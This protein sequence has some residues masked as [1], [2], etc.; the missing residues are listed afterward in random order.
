[1]AADQGS[2]HEI[3][4]QGC[5]ELLTA[6]TVGRVAF[7]DETGIVVRPVNYRVED[8]QIYLRVSPDGVLSRLAEHDGEVVF[9]VD[10]HGPT[11]RSG[12]SVIARGRARAVPDAEQARIAALEALVPWAGGDRSLVIGIVITELTGRHVRYHPS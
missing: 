3:D 8:G 7:V 10:H 1:M 4:P 2:A 5:V 11:S 9:E 6:T 12:W